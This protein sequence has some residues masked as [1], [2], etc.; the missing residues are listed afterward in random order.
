[1]TSHPHGL[2]KWAD[3]A[4]QTLDQKQPSFFKDSFELK[5]MLSELCLPH[6]ALLFTAD[7]TLMYTHIK[8]DA[9]LTVISQYIKE[10]FRT[11]PSPS[12][13]NALTTAL[14][15]IFN[16]S[17]VKFGDTYWRQISGT[18]MGIAPTP[19]WATLFYSL[20]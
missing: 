4:L 8:T 17:I 1:M 6:N 10:E 14:H 20:H 11:H 19:P 5:V 9:A 18:G 3:H 12:Y 13:T 16:N 7:S 15:I 2:G